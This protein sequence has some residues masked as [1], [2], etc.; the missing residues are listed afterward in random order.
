MQQ[1]MTKGS[2]TRHI[3]MFTL[4]VFLGNMF[5]QFY[6]MTDTA[7]VGRTLGA[8][9]L[10]AVGSTGT[11]MFLTNGFAM[12]LG[13]GFA[14]LTS[15]RF[16]AGDKDGVKRSVASG[17]LLSIFFTIVLSLGFTACMRP[18]LAWMN[19]PQDI[20]G[21]AYDYISVISEG[22]GATIFYNLFSSFLR[23][24]G[25]SQAP[26]F[27]LVISASLNI[28]LD[29]W[30]ILGLDMGVAGAAWATIASQGIAALLTLI[31]LLRRVPDLVPHGA[32]WRLRKDQVSYQLA[33][34]LPMALQFAITASG[35]MI[36]QSSIN[37]FGSTAVAAYTAANK[38]QNLFTQAMTAM[39]TTMATFC[40][41]NWGS[42]TIDR[43][44][45][46][47]LTA[48]AIMVVYSIVVAFLLTL[49]LTQML[50]L[51]FD[52]GTDLS[53]LLPWAETYIHI[54]VLFFV[55]LSLIF[56]CRNSLQ[57]C[58]YARLAM[59]SG[60]VELLARWIMAVIAKQAHSYVLSVAG[61]PAAWLTAGIY[62]VVV[63]LFTYRRMV[64][65]PKLS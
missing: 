9:A 10:A 22:L 1:D 58:G 52:A 57:G 6:N 4:P 35:T 38:I 39:G 49:L 31:Y 60:V 17:I 21:M 29:F 11:I 32:Q 19:T 48:C 12:G 30:M 63:C 41:Q 13:S 2:V 3:L 34:G 28:G 27:F 59:I 8:D 18:L 24:V 62:G 26:L 36:M 43:I 51:F 56:I 46:G 5:Q 64:K 44:R 40:G 15:Q 37:L 61:D 14:V 55:P 23:A 45:R 53:Q 20:S 50:G 65:A 54:S 7:I 47:F 42:H 16:G 33:M 25:N